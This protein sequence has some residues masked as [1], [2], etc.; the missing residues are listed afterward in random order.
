[1]SPIL[2]SPAPAIQSKA[3]PH[4]TPEEVAAKTAELLGRR[5]WC[6][7]QCEALDGEII[8]VVDTALVQHLPEGYTV[9]NLEE[10]HHL[11]KVEDSTLR[12]I[13]EAKTNGAVIVTD[14]MSQSS[15][16]SGKGN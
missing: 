13:H 4:Q 5:G 3:R 2:D 8:A 15:G 11:L 7:W 12:L 1:M 10:L 16:G 9:Y 14:A 6:L